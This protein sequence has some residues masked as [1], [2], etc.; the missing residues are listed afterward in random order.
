MTDGVLNILE[1]MTPLN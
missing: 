1:E